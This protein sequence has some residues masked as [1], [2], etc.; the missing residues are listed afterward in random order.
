MYF[1]LVQDTNVTFEF[2]GKIQEFTK[3]G[4]ILF[5]NGSEGLSHDVDYLAENL[6]YVPNPGYYNNYVLQGET[7]PRS[8]CVD[9][10][11]DTIKYVDE[12]LI[13]QAIQFYVSASEPKTFSDESTWVLKM[14]LLFA[15][16]VIL[17][18][19]FIVLVVYTC[20][21]VKRNKRNTS[22]VPITGMTP[23]LSS[24]T[25]LS[26]RDTHEIDHYYR[27]GNSK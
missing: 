11:P 15:F 2:T 1:K 17:V 16:I 6:T 27:T 19:C 22:L 5:K 9:E 4:M 14:F 10:C 3:H 13:N 23:V 25:T 18:I 20:E 21:C 12:E 8:T 24:E 7:R 26:T